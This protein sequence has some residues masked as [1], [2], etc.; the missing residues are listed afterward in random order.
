LTKEISHHV[1]ENKE[2]LKHASISHAR[3]PEGA[4][5][6]EVRL[7]AYNSEDIQ[8]FQIRTGTDLAKA[9]KAH[10]DKVLW[11]NVCGHPNAELTSAINDA[12]KM[13]H[14][15]PLEELR[16]HQRSKFELHEDQLMAIVWSATV[17]GALKTHQL[18]IV[19]GEQFVVTFQNGHHDLTA[20]VHGKLQK[21]VNKV[22]KNG[23]DYLMYSL[24]NDM[25]DGFFPCLER[26]GE[27]LE[28]V[29]NQIVDNPSKRSISQIHLIKRDLLTIRRHIWSLREMV[30]GILRDASDM[31]DKASAVHMRDSYDHL[32]QLIDFCETYRELAAD[33]M[34]VYLSSISNR[35]NEVMK[36]LTIITTIF[37]P[38]GL[39]AAIYGMNFKVMPELNWTCGYPFALGLMLVLALT[40]LSFFWWKGWLGETPK[41]LRVLRK[42]SVHA[43][44]AVTN[45]KHH[46]PSAHDSHHR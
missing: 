40:T 23:A 29:E 26:Y 35:M 18:A 44:Q 38:P 17:D 32:V 21:S 7:S 16:V 11:L 46:E 3:Q 42:K 6:C 14:F 34:D 24:V 25:I 13:H 41:F 20:A 43:A 10:K 36:V 4:G 37:V 2:A 8:D 5:V 28:S 15:V 27:R 22:R 12:F 30:N 9:V 33:L 39:I 45:H 1:Q 31:F 19:L